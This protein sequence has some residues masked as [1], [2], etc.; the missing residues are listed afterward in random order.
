M[1]FTFI[2]PRW[3]LVKGILLGNHSWNQGLWWGEK[4]GFSSLRLSA[5]CEISH[6]NRR[7]VWGETWTFGPFPHQMCPC[8]PWQP[9]QP[10]EAV[11][12]GGFMCSSI[13]PGTPWVSSEP[14]QTVTNRDNPPAPLSRTQPLPDNSGWF[15]TVS[16]SPW[17]WGNV[18]KN[19]S[20]LL[21]F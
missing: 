21:R 14:G 12:Q 1:V 20:N 8:L 13:T 10:C 18:L 2:S 9:V 11:V 5:S 3:H 19:L 6:S 15:H 7:P 16:A 17:C 4:L